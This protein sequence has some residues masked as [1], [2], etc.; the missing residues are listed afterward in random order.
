[1]TIGTKK[2]VI[3]VVS[4][5]VCTTFIEGLSYCVV[6]TGEFSLS[7]QLFALQ[8]REKFEHIQISNANC[9]QIQSSVRINNRLVDPVD[10]TVALEGHRPLLGRDVFNL[11]EFLNQ[12][13][14]TVNVPRYECLHKKQLCKDFPGLV[15]RIG[16][17]NSYSE[18]NLHKHIR[19]AE[20]YI[21]IY[22]KK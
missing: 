1:M 9:G 6:A 13:N 15:S 4:G 5:S 21:L 14:N 7:S 3:I 22:I 16:K 18:R 2:T 11:N 12:P 10:I 8:I 20:E 19:K 17:K